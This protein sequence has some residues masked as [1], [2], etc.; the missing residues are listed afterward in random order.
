[1]LQFISPR[2]NGRKKRQQVLSLSISMHAIAAAFVS[3]QIKGTI[4]FS[5]FRKRLP[6]PTEM[7]CSWKMEGG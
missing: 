3:G 2:A 1:V 6:W 5:I 4:F 7:G